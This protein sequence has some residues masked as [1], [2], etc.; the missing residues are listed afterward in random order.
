MITIYVALTLNYYFQIKQEE[1]D[2]LRVKISGDGAKMSRISSYA[3]MS[4]S[5]LAD[6]KEVMSVKGM[7]M[8]DSYAPVNV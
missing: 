6:K 8:A 4:F 2:T 1:Y 3:V 5:L 7:Q